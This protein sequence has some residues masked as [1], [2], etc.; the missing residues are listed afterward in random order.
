[1][2]IFK[3]HNI[4]FSYS[5]GS[6]VF[7][8]IDLD[9]SKKD[10][11][12]IQGESGSGKSTFLKLFNRFCSTFEGRLLFH[13]KEIREYGIERIRSSVIYLPQLPF[14]I[15]GTVRDNLSFPFTFHSHK[16]KEFDS[17][18]AGEWL[19][20][21]QLDIP[22]ERDALQLSI[23]QKQRIALIR[24]I[25]LEPEVLLLDE[26][27]SALDSKN[28]KLIE[29]KIEALIDSAGITVIMATHS[30]V[31]FTDSWVRFLNLDNRTLTEKKIGD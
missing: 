27:G 2:N 1:M 14:M 23:G 17:Q 9:I 28:K 3:L 20:Y 24:S 31:S 18:K 7:E 11:I 29:Q 19:E 10:L 6:T 4:S 16:G 21:F 22:F 25:L 26:P 15:H 8:N 30:E 12:I 5:G 13:E